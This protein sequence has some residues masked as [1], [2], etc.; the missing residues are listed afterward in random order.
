MTF[1]STS[2]TL[3]LTL[4]CAGVAH[5]Q[6][7][8]LPARPY[9]G[10]FGGGR[11]PDPNR[12]GH[13]L[14]LNVNLLGGYDDI[15]QVAGSADPNAPVQPR[16]TGSTGFAEAN[17]R[18]LLSKRERSFEVS[19]R[20]YLTSFSAGSPSLG[21][22]VQLQAAAPMGRRAR[23]R[24]SQAVRNAPY[25]SLGEFGQ[26]ESVVGLGTLPQD[27]PTLGL[28]ELRSWGL[29]SSVSVSRDWTTRQSMSASYAL[30]RTDYPDE[31]L[32][33]D[34]RS[35]TGSVDYTWRYSRVS[36]L[37]GS[38]TAANT[39]FPGR[40]NAES[41]THTM[42]G[43]LD[44][45]RRLSPTRRVTVS[46]NG[47]AVYLRNISPTTGQ[48]TGYWTPAAR[49]SVR[50]DVAR[51][52]VVNADFSRSVSVLDR[53]SVQRFAS[54][55]FAARVGGL[56]TNRLDASISGGFSQGRTAASESQSG[57]F[58]SYN[59]SAQ[60]RLALARWGA[61]TFA[62]NYYDYTLRNVFVL[63]GLPSHSTNNGFRVGIS[64]F[65]PLYGS[66]VDTGAR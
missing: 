56:I 30:G 8:D 18:Y 58:E 41:T 12:L 16:F 4:A 3:A 39:D 26:L 44:Y 23:I 7:R 38:Y 42:D 32:G 22:D 34:S 6:V 51:S 36:G 13:Q 64:F 15:T 2:V 5:A 57:E 55:A 47:G 20:G 40:E 65:L 48:L 66:A 10:L 35:Q 59:A 62:Y 27:D 60:F 11:P 9:R 25:L 29:D 50:L 17:L 45:N 21:A 46:G 33:L 43:G 1:R 19:G 24:A 31:T 53:I 14:S 49:A 54:N 52:W 61:A 37:H 28:A 63:G